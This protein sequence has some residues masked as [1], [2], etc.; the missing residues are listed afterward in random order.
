MPPLLFS[1]ALTPSPQPLLL[2]PAA[3]PEPASVRRVGLWRC[4][5]PGPLSEA[6]VRSHTRCLPHP[7]PPGTPHR[8]AVGGNRSRVPSVKCSIWVQLRT[9]FPPCERMSKSNG[10]EKRP[11]PLHAPGG[12][13][14]RHQPPW[15]SQ[16]A[17]LC[18]S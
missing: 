15:A 8:A 3:T 12:S 7:L 13:S 14:Q 1:Q 4:P 16:R 6:R 17:A 11:R 2:T 10:R 9:Y 5:Q 18:A